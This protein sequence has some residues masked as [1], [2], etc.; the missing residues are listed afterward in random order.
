MLDRNEEE[1]VCADHLHSM[2]RDEFRGEKKTRARACPRQKK[3]G[4]SVTKCSHSGKKKVTSKKK[5]QMKPVI[6][7]VEGEKRGGEWLNGRTTWRQTGK[8]GVGGGG[9][10][11]RVA[12]S[13]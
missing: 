10:G 1:K 12:Q 6:E 3:E 4:N 11:K 13:K 2:A 7:A 9:K 8:K 5:R